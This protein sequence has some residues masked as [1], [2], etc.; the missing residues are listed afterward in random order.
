M[1]C[2]FMRQTGWQLGRLNAVSRKSGLTSPS[3]SSGTSSCCHSTGFPAAG[4]VLKRP[5]ESAIRHAFGLSKN[6]DFATQK[7]PGFKM[8]GIKNQLDR[9]NYLHT[10]FIRYMNGSES[11]KDLTQSLGRRR[12]E[13]LALT[14]S[15]F[16]KKGLRDSS[17]Q[18]S[19]QESVSIIMATP[20]PQSRFIFGYTN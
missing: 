8:N 1:S 12:R 17:S 14:I 5:G 3:S 10:I 19:N 9:L 6:Q 18:S 2:G 7:I 13:M 4:H 16:V 20:F 11:F 15:L